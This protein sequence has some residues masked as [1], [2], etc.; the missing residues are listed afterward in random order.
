MAAVADRTARRILAAGILALAFGCDKA[1]HAS[2]DAGATPVD[3]EVKAT[4]FDA[5]TPKLAVHEEPKGP[6]CRI[7]SGEN[8]PPRTA[9]PGTWLNLAAHATFSTRVDETA[10][11]IRFEGPGRM[12]ACG[13]DDVAFV[14]EGSAMAMPGGGEAP[15]AE[16]WVATACTVARWAG[17]MHRV[18][19][20]A[21]ECT[22][23]SSLGAMQIYVAEDVVAED[24]SSDAGAPKPFPAANGFTRID[25]RQI[26]RF[27]PRAATSE[28]A[29]IE[30]A[31]VTCEQR[32]ADV[33][34][35]GTELASGAAQD[36]G[37]GVVAER[38]VTARGLARAACALAA[39]RV[40][41][42]GARPADAERLE[43]ASARFR[44]V[45][46]AAKGP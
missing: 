30:R 18:T 17:G 29:M 31:L 34:R 22:I 15:G 1:E 43:K 10:R 4:P 32:A 20:A 35:L 2:P 23:H 12:R 41:L 3:A 27:R 36:G 26:L 40:D 28:R 9:D 8:G 33:A 44:G 24:V 11:E 19:G 37:F 5:S 42:G 7:V 14:S 39:V 16:Q 25:T 38:S 13:P 21:K 6:R 45:T 46:T